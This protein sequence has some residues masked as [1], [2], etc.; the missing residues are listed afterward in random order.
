MVIAILSKDEFSERRAALRNTWIRTIN[1]LKTQLPFRLV[2][3]FFLDKMS[4][5]TNGEYI[6]QRDIVYLNVSEHGW[7]IKFGK[8]MFVLLKYIHQ[9]YPE[10]DLGIR[11]DD[12]VFLCVPQIFQRLKEIM[13]PNLYYGLTFSDKKNIGPIDEMFLV[14]GK[15]II[16]WVA[17]QTFCEYSKCEN[18]TLQDA[19]HGTISLLNWIQHYKDI[20]FYS[21]FRRI[22]HINVSAT[23]TK[24]RKYATLGYCMDHFVFHKVK[25]SS[26]MYK[27]H[28]NNEILKAITSKVILLSGKAFLDD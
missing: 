13:S 5:E 1:K 22:K 20:D 23:E 8:K 16:N 7:S 11:V 6:T 3:K 14:L 4:K 26:F 24:W 28:E 10:A 25:I 2:Y 19:G 12:D 27:M 18:N 9:N 21:D 15:H 17:N